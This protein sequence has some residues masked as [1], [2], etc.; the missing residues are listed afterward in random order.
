ME[1]KFIG[2]LYKGIKST[3]F[4]EASTLEDRVTLYWDSVY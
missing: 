2:F 3:L 1:C 4:S